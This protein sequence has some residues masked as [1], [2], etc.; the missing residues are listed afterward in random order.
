M[1]HTGIGMSGEDF[2]RAKMSGTQA[3]RLAGCAVC[4]LMICVLAVWNRTLVLEPAAEFLRGC[5]G[6][7]EEKEIL[8]EN[9]LSDRVRGK[10][11]LLSL[12]GGYAHLMGRTK[13]NGV[14]TLTNG[15]LSAS[16]EYL[17]TEA[18]ADN[19]ERYYRY[20]E[21]QHIPFLYIIAPHK[22]A[23]EENLLPA[24]AS[25]LTNEV[26]DQVFRQLTERGVP[27]LDLRKEMSRT[28]EQIETYFYRTD[29]HW[30]VE[31]SFF[32]YQRIMQAVQAY[33]PETKMT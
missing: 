1:D 16:M 23:T 31:G 21:G 32:A 7:E 3:V 5:I 14:Q 22:V 19:V 2:M 4:C 26:G 18:F 9:Y 6:F 25:D 13:Y 24:G 27:V 20:L 17:D 10:N 29:H 11:E 28:R 30:N 8:Q 12:N 15:M 33:F